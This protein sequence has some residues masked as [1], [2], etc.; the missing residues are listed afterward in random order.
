MIWLSNNFVNILVIL[1][2]VVLLYLC[3]RSLIKDK[4]CGGCAGCSKGCANCSM[5]S[6]HSLKDRRI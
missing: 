5:C 1:S 3:I 2:I 6:G 4:S